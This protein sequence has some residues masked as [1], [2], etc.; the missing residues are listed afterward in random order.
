[1]T[2]RRHRRA[3][4]QA[5]PRVKAREATIRRMIE[6]ERA[7]TGTAPSAEHIATLLACSVERVRVHMA[8]IVGGAPCGT[9][10]LL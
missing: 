2:A 3:H 6:V 7:R 5:G 8:K 10:R 4:N 9:P 1:M